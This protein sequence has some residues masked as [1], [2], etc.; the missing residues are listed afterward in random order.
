[1]DQRNQTY[2]ISAIIVN[3]LSEISENAL[4][5]RRNKVYAIAFGASAVAL[6]IASCV[7]FLVP[8]EVTSF[9]TKNQV[10]LPFNSAYWSKVEP[11]LKSSCSSVRELAELISAN[12]IDAGVPL[13]AS[14][15]DIELMLKRIDVEYFLNN[16]LPLLKIFI[17][18]SKDLFSESYHLLT[19]DNP[20]PLTFTAK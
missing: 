16:T 11:R 14:A 4:G 1:M 7:L 9:H 2:T 13:P 5:I 15:D 6:L 18:Q 8:S 10:S 17:L 12:Q 20:G 3:L 19:S